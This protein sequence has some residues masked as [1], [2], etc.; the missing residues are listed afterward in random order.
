MATISYSQSVAINAWFWR[1]SWNTI[2]RTQMPCRIHSNTFCCYTLLKIQ[3]L[4]DVYQDEILLF[5]NYWHIMGELFY[6]INSVWSRSYSLFCILLTCFTWWENA[7]TDWC[8]G[9]LS[10]FC[11]T[12]FSSYYIQVLWTYAHWS[13]RYHIKA[14]WPIQRISV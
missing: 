7:C 14:L 2:I 13:C 11:C 4:R 5:S 12:S 1:C 10:E 6:F 3:N 9:W 8:I